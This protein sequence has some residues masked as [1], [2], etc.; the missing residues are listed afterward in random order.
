MAS[1]SASESTWGPRET[2]MRNAVSFMS[3]SSLSPIMPVLSGVKGRV[4]ATKSARGRRL[5]ER[6][7]LFHLEAHRLEFPARS[8]VGAYFHLEGGGAPCERSPDVPETHDTQ[9]RALKLKVEPALPGR[10]EPG[11]SR[12]DEGERHGVFRHGD[13]AHRAGR[14]GDGDA[15]FRGG[16]NVYVVHAGPHLADHLDVR[17]RLHEFPRDGGEPGGQRASGNRQALA[18]SSRRAGFVDNVSSKD[19]LVG[20]KNELIPLMADIPP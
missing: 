18:A 12:H 5:V 14:V 8:R 15:E 13:A 6:F 16:L 11:P 4:S 17:P 7:H 10:P 19:I 9:R 20:L 2:L 3:S 1:V